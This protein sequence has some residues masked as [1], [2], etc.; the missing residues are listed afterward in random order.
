MSMPVPRNASSFTPL[1][2]QA[3]LSRTLTVWDKEARCH[4]VVAR[5]S[6]EPH[7]W[8]QYLAGAVIGYRK[9]GAEKALDYPRIKD[10]NSTAMFVV[11][12][13]P[14]GTVCG[15]GRTEGPYARADQAHAIAEWGTHPG[16]DTVRQMIDERLQAGI[17]EA[18]GVWVA[19]NASHRDRLVALTARF[20]KYSMELLDVRF[21]MATAAAHVLDTWRATTGGVVAEHIPGVPYPDDRYVTQLM[22]WDRHIPLSSAETAQL[23]E[24]LKSS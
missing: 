2:T 22:W 8:K 17:I 7:L 20:L 5:P 13:Q 3:R 18:K 21:I 4:F 12:V 10:G 16:A 1:P 15:G 19:C 14:D 24:L 23:E 6:L 11:A 9:F